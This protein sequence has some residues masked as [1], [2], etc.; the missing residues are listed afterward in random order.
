MK[1]I[2]CVVSIVLAGCAS[3]PVH[4]PERVET[5][6]LPRL[7]YVVRIPPEEL[8]KL[9]EKVPNI[10]VDTATQADVARWIIANEARTNSL[11]NII[12]S[13]MKY[14][15]DEQVAHDEKAKIENEKFGTSGDPSKVI[16][17]K[18]EEKK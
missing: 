2:L 7:E 3:T 4:V 12:I 16:T 15:R 1:A 9:P 18:P 10:N 13:I 8:A 11:E 5:K 17:P 14:L 6:I